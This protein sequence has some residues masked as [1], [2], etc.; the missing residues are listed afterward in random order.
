MNEAEQQLLEQAKLHKR[1][2]A[3]AVRERQQLLHDVQNQISALKFQY[4]D[5]SL[6]FKALHLAFEAVRISWYAVDHNK[7]GCLGHRDDLDAAM[8]WLSGH[9]EEM[10]HG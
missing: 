7:D 10:D 2:Q 9:L 4:R 8:E 6:E 1:V 3:M 5:S